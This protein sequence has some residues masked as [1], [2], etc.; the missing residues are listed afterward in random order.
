MFSS[1]SKKDNE[2]SQAIRKSVR[3]AVENSLDNHQQMKSVA[4]AYSSKRECSV[5]ESA[6]HVMSE[7]WL[8]K[9]YPGVI[10]ANTNLPKKRMKMILRE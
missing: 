2:C 4:H 8:R 3:E 5:Q 7:L 9:I 10:H 6:Y 1:V